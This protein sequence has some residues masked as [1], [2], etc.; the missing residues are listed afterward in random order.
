MTVVKMNQPH[1]KLY[2]APHTM[3]PMRGMPLTMS[4]LGV[5]KDSRE[6]T[7]VSETTRNSSA[8]DNVRSKNDAMALYYMQRSQVTTKAEQI[9]LST[10]NISG[11]RKLAMRQSPPSTE[12]A[13]KPAQGTPE[14]STLSEGSVR[15]QVL[16]NG[17]VRIISTENGFYSFPKETRSRRERS[18]ISNE[19]SSKSRSSGSEREN[20]GQLRFSRHLSSSGC[21]YSDVTKEDLVK[22]YLQHCD[23]WKLIERHMVG[24]FFG[25]NSQKQWRYSTF[26][27]IIFILFNRRQWE[28]AQVNKLPQDKSSWSRVSLF[29]GGIT[30]SI[31]VILCRTLYL[32]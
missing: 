29:L 14:P 16:A 5:G 17:Q 23:G 26:G 4:G 2:T 9:A 30:T 1:L 6:A 19:T 31:V 11:A 12:T 20:P 7:M 28:G 13:V 27:L 10:L 18:F 3:Q 15:A 22:A 24:K 32:Y 25:Q 21:D 8:G